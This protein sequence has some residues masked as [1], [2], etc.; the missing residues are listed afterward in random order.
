MKRNERHDV[1]TKEKLERTYRAG[2]KGIEV[3]HEEVKQR[4]IAVAAKLERYD[5]RT[6]Q[7]RQNRRRKS[8]LM[9]DRGKKDKL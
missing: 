1:V 7:L 6:K 2:E 3:V 5:D 8:C 9:S 4:L